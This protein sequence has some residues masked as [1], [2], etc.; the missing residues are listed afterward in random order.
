MSPKYT[1]LAL[2]LDGTLLNNT[3]TISERTQATLAKVA[4]TGALIAICSGR[5]TYCTEPFA[6]PF[7]FPVHLL[8]FNGGMALAPSLAE[9]SPRPVLFSEK[10][11]QEQV[12]QVLTAAEKLNRNLN[13]YDSDVIHAVIRNPEQ[14]ALVHRYKTQCNAPYNIIE[15]YKTLTHLPPKLCVFAND[16]ARVAEYLESHTTGLKIIKEE[17]HVECLPPLTNKGDGFV[18]MCSALGIPISQTV[19][20][21]DGL[22]DLEF[23]KNAGRG[24]AMRNGKKEVLESAD[25]V[26]E[27]TNNDDGV[28]VELER[29]LAEGLFDRTSRT[30]VSNNA[31]FW[32]GCDWLWDNSLA[33]LMLANTLAPECFAHVT[34]LTVK[35][36]QLRSHDSAVA[37]LLAKSA[38]FETLYIQC[39]MPSQESQA[40]ASQSHNDPVHTPASESNTLLNTKH[41]IFAE[42]KALLQRIMGVYSVL[43][44][45]I[46]QELDTE[47]YVTYIVL[48]TGHPVE[49]EFDFTPALPIC[50]KCRKN[51]SHEAE[52]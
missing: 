45:F 38:H 35:S 29:M 51:Q 4:A 27:F 13:F 12:T 32:Q 31:S 5:A 44:P 7:D 30:I 36:D 8:T 16:S 34:S 46:F 2:D 23:V 14:A 39:T 25:Y 9:G 22:N 28:A 1:L 37:A 15:D 42:V 52:P 33:L 10:M 6:A 47:Y 50:F 49:I 24:V 40:D 17:Y 21:G 18:R 41:A 11:T 3:H 48:D 43:D 26:T 20:F 19:A